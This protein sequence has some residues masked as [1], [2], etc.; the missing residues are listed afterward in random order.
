MGVESAIRPRL[1][2][3]LKE[4][5]AGLTSKQAHHL[6]GV[7]AN[8]VNKQIRALG[9]AGE[10]ALMRQSYVTVMCLTEHAPA[11]RARLRAESEDK[12]R[13]DK[14]RKAAWNRKHL[15][16]IDEAPMEDDAPPIQRWVSVAMAKPIKPR[17]PASVWELAK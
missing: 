5:P 7:S 2:D 14:L 8:G 9:E 3:L 16:G 12:A 1:L 13:R 4:H 11:V 6:L 17:G 15:T 10:I